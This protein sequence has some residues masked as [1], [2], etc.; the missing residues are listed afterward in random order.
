MTTGA[1]EIAQRLLAF[2]CAN[3][4]ALKLSNRVVRPE[5]CSSVHRST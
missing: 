5:E 3:A 1:R 2:W 4:V